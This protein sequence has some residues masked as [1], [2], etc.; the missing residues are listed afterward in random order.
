MAD[1]EESGRDLLS[2]LLLAA[3]FGVVV[4]MFVGMRLAN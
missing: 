4:I 2:W 3:A 1:K